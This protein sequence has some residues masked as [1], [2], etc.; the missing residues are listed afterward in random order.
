MSMYNKAGSKKK[1]I[2]FD[3]IKFDSQ[4][5]LD[6]YHWCEEAYEH[7][8]IEG[9]LYHP[10]S[11][12]LSERVTYTKTIQLKT[13]VKTKECF[14]MNPCTYG[15]DFIIVINDKFREAFKGVIVDLNENGE[16]HIDIKGDFMS[17]DASHKFSII[18]KWVY[19]KLGIYV[20]KVISDK[21]F[22]KTWCPENAYWKKNKLE[23]Y[24]RYKDCKLIK[25]L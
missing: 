19:D 4:T 8:Y 14:L 2:I 11:L 24:K 7:G 12:T 25:D 17:N 6:F 5:E 15:A 13:K 10:D 18:Q 16:V 9:Y 1:D 22:T 20:K 23:P 21:F 3:D